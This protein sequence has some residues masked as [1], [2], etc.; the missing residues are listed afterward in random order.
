MHILKVR[1]AL[2]ITSLTRSILTMIQIYLVEGGFQ[3]VLLP[4]DGDKAAGEP[5]QRSSY[6]KSY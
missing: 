2:Q 5:L 6:L 3:S 4:T 1:I